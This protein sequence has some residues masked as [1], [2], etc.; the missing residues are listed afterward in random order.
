MWSHFLEDKH[1]VVNIQ[2]DQTAAFEVVDHD[3]LIR[4]LKVLGA[5]ENT[6]KWFKSYM[7]DRRQTVQL[8]GGLSSE[9]TLEPYG[10]VQ[11]SVLASLMYL[12][13]VLDFP[14]LFHN[15]KHTPIEDVKCRQETAL[16]YVDNINNTVKSVE[17][18]PLQK[19]MTNS[20]ETCKVL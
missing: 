20:L 10:T 13:F 9:L 12:I 6:V 2:L 16:T 14:L 17:N 15:T 11:G 7:T 5:D 19:T 3:I 4:K 1:D 8:E 18:E